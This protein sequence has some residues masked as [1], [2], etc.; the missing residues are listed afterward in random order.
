MSCSTAM[1]TLEQVPSIDTY[2]IMFS[3]FSGHFSYRTPS[4]ILYKSGS[5]VSFGHEA[6]EWFTNKTR[7]TV[8]DADQYEFFYDVSYNSVLL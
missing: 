4:A 2:V 5:P 8:E 7:E 3:D 1:V 6:C